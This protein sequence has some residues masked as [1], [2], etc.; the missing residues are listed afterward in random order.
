MPLKVLLQGESLQVQGTIHKTAFYEIRRIRARRQLQQ[1]QDDIKAEQ[2]CSPHAT[3]KLQDSFV[4][5][6]SPP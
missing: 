1:C 2:K 4:W 3:N 6:D 5:T